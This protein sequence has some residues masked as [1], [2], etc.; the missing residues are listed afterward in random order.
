MKVD[1]M[2][3]CLSGVS[4]LDGDK[5]EIGLFFP[6]TIWIDGEGFRVSGRISQHI[7]P[8][9]KTFFFFLSLR[10][11]ED[12]EKVSKSNETP[13]VKRDVCLTTKCISPSISP[14]WVT[15]VSIHS[16]CLTFACVFPPLVALFSS[17]RFLFPFCF[18]LQI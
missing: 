4:T 9:Q 17:G 13:L 6:S 14:I 18:L 2:R 5:I 1:C 10:A 3:N 16:S 7:R 8:N 11:N 12:Q 15:E